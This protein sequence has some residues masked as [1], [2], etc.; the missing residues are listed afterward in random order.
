M[1]D[2]ALAWQSLSAATIEGGGEAPARSGLNGPLIVPNNAYH[3]ADGQL[4]ITV[5]T[6]KQF[7]RLCDAIGKPEIAADP[8]FC[9]NNARVQNEDQLTQLIEAELGKA[10]RSHWSALFDSIEVPNAPIQSLKEALAHKQVQASGILKPSP[11]GSYQLVGNALKFDGKR[12]GFE[13]EAPELG[14]ANAA[15]FPASED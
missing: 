11:D 5:G 3:T 12:P 13:A 15:M 1:F 4:L 2:T 14:E 10:P 9:N 8:L 6:N 7:A